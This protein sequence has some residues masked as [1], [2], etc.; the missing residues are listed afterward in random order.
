MTRVEEGARKG[1]NNISFPHNITPLQSTQVVTHPMI[2]T[3]ALLLI[4]P[5]SNKKYSGGV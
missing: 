5:H 4:N 2:T 1:V 3:N